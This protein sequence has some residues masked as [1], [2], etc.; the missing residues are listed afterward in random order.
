MN[1]HKQIFDEIQR[2]LRKAYCKHEN[3]IDV[4][5]NDHKDETCIYCADNTQTEE[6]L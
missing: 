1:I 3:T 2:E 5:D 4:G 6:I